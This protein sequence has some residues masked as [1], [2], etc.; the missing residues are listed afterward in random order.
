[1]DA[2]LTAVV[3]RPQQHGFHGA[4][5]ARAW[6]SAEQH[7]PVTADGLHRCLLFVVELRIALAVGAVARRLVCRTLSRGAQLASLHQAVLQRGHALMPA[8]P[9]QLVAVQHHQGGVFAEPAAAVQGLAVGGWPSLGRQ[10]FGL[11]RTIAE[12]HAHFTA[13]E[14]VG[15]CL[16]E[17]LQRCLLQGGQLLRQGTAAGQHRYQSPAEGLCC[18]VVQ[19]LLAHASPRSTASSFCRRCRGARS[20]TTPPP[21]CGETPL[22]N[23]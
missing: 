3:D 13:T 10:A 1:M 2:Q 5:F 8:L 15:E 20:R 21:C 12:V 11:G 22:R 14:G 7:Q 18:S 9:Q 23:T 4:G 17:I 6:T 19:R 16:H